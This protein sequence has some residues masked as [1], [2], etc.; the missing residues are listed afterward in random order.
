MNLESMVRK[1]VEVNVSA[2]HVH[3]TQEAYTYLTGK[4][5]LT[6]AKDLKQ[7]GQYLAEERLTLQYGDNEERQF[8]NVG[9]LGP[10][11]RYCQ[12]ELAGSDAIWLK[13]YE[14]RMLRLSGDIENTPGMT[15]I[16]GDKRYKME[17]GV[18]VPLAHLHIPESRAE[19]Y[20]VK[21]G[22]DVDLYINCGKRKTTRQ[23]R[24]RVG[25]NDTTYYEV[26]IDTDEGNGAGVKI[27]AEGE[28][29]IPSV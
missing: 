26:H 12:V 15:L 25:P 24:I 6:W 4:K 8:H 2:R 9:I 17:R 28:L 7:P 16:H 20:G 14:D 21:D 10:F 5:D 3:V 11:R 18:I 29:I 27:S 19:E 23:I 22:Q 13:M 1:N